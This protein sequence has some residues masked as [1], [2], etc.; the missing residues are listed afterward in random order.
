MD[1]MVAA[2]SR[3]NVDRVRQEDVPRSA[4]HRPKKVDV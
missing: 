2:A 1:K 3:F 4:A